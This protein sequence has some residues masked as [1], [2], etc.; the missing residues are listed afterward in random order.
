[1]ILIQKL[2]ITRWSPVA[3]DKKEG[4]FYNQEYLPFL[5]KLLILKHMHNFGSI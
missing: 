1:M 5:I 2:F 4:Q 3:N